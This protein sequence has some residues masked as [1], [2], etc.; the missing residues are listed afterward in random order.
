ML[1]IFKHRILN[2]IQHIHVFHYFP[3]NFYYIIYFPFTAGINLFEKF[4]VLCQ[5]ADILYMQNIL[6]NSQG[7]FAFNN[8]QMNTQILQHGEY[9]SCIFKRSDPCIKMKTVTGK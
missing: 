4:L 2:A 7:Y 5:T 9:D 6:F 3:D 1:Q 8:I